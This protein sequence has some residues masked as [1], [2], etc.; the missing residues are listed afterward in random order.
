MPVREGLFDCSKHDGVFLML[1]LMLWLLI[2]FLIDAL[3]FV[4]SVMLS[5]ETAKGDYPN[6]ALEMMSKICREA[7]MAIDYRS[8]FLD[9]RKATQ[10]MRR[11]SGTTTE[12]D[13]RLDALATSC[14]VAADEVRWWFLLCGCCGRCSLAVPMHWFSDRVV[15]CFYDCRPVSAGIDSASGTVVHVPVVEC[16]SDHCLDEKW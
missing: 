5:G 13:H 2:V 10:N 4:H 6:E 3:F 15:V 14:V 16:Q 12:I 1:F 8:L 9:L 11:A 7:E